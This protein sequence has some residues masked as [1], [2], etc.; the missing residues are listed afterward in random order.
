MGSGFACVVG[1]GRNNTALGAY[2]AVG[3]GLDDT[4]HGYYST[5]PGGER[6]EARGNHSFAGGRRAKA[7]TAAPSSGE[8][9]R[10]PNAHLLPPRTSG[11]TIRSWIQIR[12]LIRAAA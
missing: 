12:V 2:A 5:V 1:G 9:P 11:E 7:I 10:T 6:N 3:G 8:T 4:A